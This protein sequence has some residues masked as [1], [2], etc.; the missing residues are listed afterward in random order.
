MYYFVK[1]GCLQT[2]LVQ[3]ILNVLNVIYSSFYLENVNNL[4]CINTF[5]KRVI[6]RMFSR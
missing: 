5:F 4:T 3:P 6:N 1:D 2:S